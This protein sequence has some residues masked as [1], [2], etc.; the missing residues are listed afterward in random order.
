MAPLNQL[1]ATYPR[2]RH[3]HVVLP[4]PGCAFYQSCA[5]RIISSLFDYAS[6]NLHVSGQ[7]KVASTYLITES[8]PERLQWV[9]SVEKLGNVGPWTEILAA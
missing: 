4:E 7:V 8:S 5:I 6:K 9:Y 3:F 1:L 2:H